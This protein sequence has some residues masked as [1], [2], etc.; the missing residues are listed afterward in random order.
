[1]GVEKNQRLWRGKARI[2]SK[3]LCGWVIGNAPAIDS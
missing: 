3:I 2:S 1:M